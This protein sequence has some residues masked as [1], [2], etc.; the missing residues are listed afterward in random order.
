MLVKRFLPAVVV[1]ALL[2]AAC[3]ADSDATQ[4]VV[5]PPAPESSQPLAQPATTAEP[6][7]EPSLLGVTA[8]ELETYCDAVE[9]EWA[10]FNTVD[11]GNTELS[12]Q[13]ADAFRRIADVAPP[14]QAGL[15]VVLASEQDAY[16]R[17]PTDDDRDVIADGVRAL[18]KLEGL[19]SEFCP[20]LELPT[21]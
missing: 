15:W 4:S 1:T 18:T 7:S 9:T 14:D 10:L 17:G 11:I 6:V 5:T 21:P 13:Q 19:L 8:T 20:D 12:Q 16:T 3:G 2:V